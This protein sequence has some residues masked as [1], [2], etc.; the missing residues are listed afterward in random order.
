M[1]FQKFLII[2]NSIYIYRSQLSDII[3]N[4]SCLSLH[5]RK[6]SKFLFSV[7]NSIIGSNLILGPH[8]G[9]PLFPVLL[10]LV[11]LSLQ[12]VTFLIQKS[13]LTGQIISFLKKIFMLRSSALFLL[14]QIF[15]LHLCLFFMKDR[16]FRLFF[17]LSDHLLLLFHLFTAVSKRLI[18]ILF[19]SHKSCD[20][21]FQTAQVFL[22]K[23]LFLFKSG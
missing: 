16:L 8:I 12:T 7:G 23:F 17:Q 19:L 15:Q 5:L 14:L 2:L 21:C 1:S 6:I 13:D 20:F 4:L 18:N 10:Q 11:H 3:F 9:N 22:V